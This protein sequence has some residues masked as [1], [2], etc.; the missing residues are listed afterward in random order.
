MHGNQCMHFSKH[1]SKWNTGL[2]C[3]L[4][5]APL[6]QV[7]AKLSITLLSAQKFIS[8]AIIRLQ[9]LSLASNSSLFDDITVFKFLCD[10]FIRVMIGRRLSDPTH[11]TEI[12][13]CYVPN[14]Y[15]ANEHTEG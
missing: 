15:K 10:C 7:C 2:E 4:M 1:I 5:Y 9:C 8:L 13:N 6:I 14:S 12:Y 11:Y 3:I